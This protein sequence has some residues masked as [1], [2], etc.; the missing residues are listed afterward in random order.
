MRAFAVIAVAYF[1]A[2][3]GLDSAQAQSAAHRQELG[4]PCASV[5]DGSVEIVR[6]SSRGTS[7]DPVAIETLF[8]VPEREE[9]V[10][11]I[12]MLHSARGLR[13]PE[14]YAPIQR[15]FA[16]WGYASLVIDHASGG[17]EGKGRGFEASSYDRIHD[18]QAA[19]DFLN[20][21]NRVESGELFAVGWSRGA[22]TLLASFSEL[23]S[24]SNGTRPALKAA[25]AYYPLCPSALK[26]LAVP[27]ILFHGADDRMTPVAS[28]RALKVPPE[29]KS[30]YRFV[31]FSGVDHLFDHP[32]EHEYNVSAAALSLNQ[33]RAFFESAISRGK[34]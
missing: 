28:C 18:L 2:L 24:L 17:V 16:G 10:P 26:S 1:A 20:T 29:K 11:A 31:E 8:M 6:L 13:P 34:E 3:T 15:L 27:L 12:I 21:D 23:P 33:M 7:G 19:I 30:I 5:L 9:A 22:M 25:A 4:N 14:C 32:W